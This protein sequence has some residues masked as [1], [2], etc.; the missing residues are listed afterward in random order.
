MTQIALI[1]WL[2]L[3]HINY[4]YAILGGLFIEDTEFYKKDFNSSEISNN[5]LLLV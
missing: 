5:H 4:S 2:P 1:P 3:D